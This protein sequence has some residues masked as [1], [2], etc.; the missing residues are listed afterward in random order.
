MIGIF[1]RNQRPTA[2][3]II[4]VSVLELEL[5]A[6]VVQAWTDVLRTEIRVL[7]RVLPVDPDRVVDVAVVVACFAEVDLFGE[8]GGGEEDR[9]EGDGGEGLHGC[10]GWLDGYVGAGGR[11]T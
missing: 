2:I 10:L 8:G 1:E 11:N 5:P 3:K 9:E 6:V 4:P 7:T